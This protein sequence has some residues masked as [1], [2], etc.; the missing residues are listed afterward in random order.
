MTEIELRRWRWCVCL[1]VLV[2]VVWMSYSRQGRDHRLG[3]KL[4]EGGAACDERMTRLHGALMAF[5][6]AHDGRLPASLD[7]LVDS[8]YARHEDTLT[9]GSPGGTAEY[10]SLLPASRRDKRARETDFHGSVVVQ[11]R[12]FGES[13]TTSDPPDT[14]ILAEEAA[15]FFRGQ[16]PTVILF[17]D[18]RILAYGV[19]EG[20]SLIES[21]RRDVATSAPSGGAPTAPSAGG[22]VSSPRP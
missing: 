20:R 13:A 21:R 12:Y 7:A 22:L 8:G 17:L 4:A 16:P 14:P 6:A 1:A 11:Y 19:P 15:P 5:A 9:C 10:L 18:G 3:A 2:V